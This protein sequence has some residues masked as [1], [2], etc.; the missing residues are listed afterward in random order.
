MTIY[1]IKRTMC[2]YEATTVE[3]LR[4]GFKEPYE[5]EDHIL[6]LITTYDEHRIDRVLD[7]CKDDIEAPLY[8]VYYATKYTRPYTTQ[9][10]YTIEEVEV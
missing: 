10:I 3:V 9:Y 8:C 1:C 4:K 6:S 7:Y 5:A 2:D